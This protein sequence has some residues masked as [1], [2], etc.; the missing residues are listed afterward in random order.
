MVAILALGKLM[1]EASE[2]KITLGCFTARLYLKKENEIGR[3]HLSP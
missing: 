1:Q 3:D 2:F